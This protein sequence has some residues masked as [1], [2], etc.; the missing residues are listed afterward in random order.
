MQYKQKQPQTLNYNNSIKFLEEK[1]DEDETN[2]KEWK[3]KN[4]IR[5]NMENE[6]ICFVYCVG[7]W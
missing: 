2:L 4:G 5:K 3:P 6:N 1:K 7:I